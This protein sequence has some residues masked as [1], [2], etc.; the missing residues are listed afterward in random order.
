MS[1]FN[2]DIGLSVTTGSYI[3]TKKLAFGEVESKLASKES[4]LLLRQVVF[5]FQ[6]IFKEKRR[7]TSFF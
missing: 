3:K 1:R 2:L 6:D 7:G 4:K 5:V